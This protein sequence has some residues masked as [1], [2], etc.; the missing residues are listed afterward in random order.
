ML[1]LAP[2]GAACGGGSDSARPNFERTDST[3]VDSSWPTRLRVYAVAHLTEPA[4]ARN[5]GFEGATRTRLDPTLERY[6]YERDGATLDVF[7]DDGLDRPYHSV[8]YTRQPAFEPIPWSTSAQLRQRWTEA[9]TAATALVRGLTQLTPVVNVGAGTDAD[10]ALALAEGFTFFLLADG[11][12]VFVDDARA[13]VGIYGVHSLHLDETPYQV[14]PSG[15]IDVRT[16]AEVDTIM[17]EAGL[18]AF[19][20]FPRDPIFY[21]YFPD[22]M[23]LQPF[24]LAVQPEGGPRPILLDKAVS[25]LAP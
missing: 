7:F 19:T 18:T 5:L 9:A 6:R 2:L 3:A 17:A 21:G 4:V 20:G 25:P 23:R 22:A 24:F 8:T 1:V 10:Y 14:A 13:E 12:L 11:R 16:R 15:E